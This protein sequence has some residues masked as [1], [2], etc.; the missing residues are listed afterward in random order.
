M[1]QTLSPLIVNNAVDLADGFM[2]G[3]STTAKSKII[4]FY[5]RKRSSTGKTFH[6]F[7]RRV[8]ERWKHREDGTGF[9]LHH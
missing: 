5:L 4:Y 6:P 8:V 3:G 7:I 2:N 9:N 1:E